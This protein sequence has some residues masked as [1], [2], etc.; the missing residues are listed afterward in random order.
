MEKTEKPHPKIHGLWNLAAILRDDWNPEDR[1]LFNTLSD[2]AIAARYDD[3]T[4]A[5]RFATIEN[6]KHWISRTE[7]FLSRFLQ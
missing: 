5:E 4:W 6:V 3:P 1:E 7:E 2:F